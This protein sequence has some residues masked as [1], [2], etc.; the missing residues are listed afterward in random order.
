MTKLDNLRALREIKDLTREELAKKSGVNKFTIQALEDG[1]TNTNE[2]KLSTLVKLAKAL[3]CKVVDLV[4]K[5][6][7]K[8]IR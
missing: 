2:V 1:R 8:Y 7:K 3:N 5:D 4:D 6:L